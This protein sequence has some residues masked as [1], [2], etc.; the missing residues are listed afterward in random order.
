MY[1]G[2]VAEIAPVEHLFAAP[3]HPYTAL[4]LA[5]V[6]RLDVAPKATL[7]TIEG[8]VPTPDEFGEGCRFASRCPL[9]IANAARRRRRSARAGHAAP[10]GGRRRAQPMRVDA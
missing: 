8:R 9:A 3:G 2:R 1:A 10:A 4:L 5:S 6:P 7:A